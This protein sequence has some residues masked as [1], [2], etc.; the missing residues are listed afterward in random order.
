M[1]E[2][3]SSAVLLTGSTGFLGSHLCRALLDR[4]VEVHCLARAGGGSSAEQRVR[5][6]LASTEPEAGRRAQQPIVHDEDLTTLDPE[7]WSSRLA[8]RTAISEVWHCAASTDLGQSEIRSLEGPNV[9]ATRRM[10]ALADSLGVDRF[11]FVS[12]AYQC[13]RS[14]DDIPECRTPSPRAGFR[15]AY[16]QSKWMAEQVLWDWKDASQKLT[17]YRPAIVLGATGAARIMHWQGFYLYV[18]QLG[19]LLRNRARRSQRGTTF[20]PLT[21]PGR[22]A[23][24]LNLVFVD[25]VVRSMEI[26][27]RDPRSRGNAFHLVADACWTVDQ[28]N[29]HFQE[30][31]GDAE[32][33]LCDDPAVLKAWEKSPV[34]SCLAPYLLSSPRFVTSKTR[35]ILADHGYSAPGM[36]DALVRHQ[37]AL[38][39][40]GSPDRALAAVQ[41]G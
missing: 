29:Q 35:A 12:T 21:I 1:Q 30:I 8:S 33:M 6:S 14:S 38:A 31:L 2:K 7:A 26:L 34:F 37:F 24:E 27:A 10:L 19:R 40:E 32:L 11:H 4:G 16:E 25:A 13:G 20:S 5:A 23:T 9:E 22:G 17:V 28:L 36:T 18:H 15:N 41:A 39:L 3:R